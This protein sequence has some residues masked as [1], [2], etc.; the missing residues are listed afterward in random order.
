MLKKKGFYISANM[1]F[2]ETM[3]PKASKCT[4]VK[5][6]YL[7]SFTYLFLFYLY[8]RSILQTSKKAYFQFNS[9][10][11]HPLLCN[12]ALGHIMEAITQI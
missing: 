12:R 8:S 3:K 1:G 5:K 10:D 2:W 11:I 9:L 4:D 6:T 7:L